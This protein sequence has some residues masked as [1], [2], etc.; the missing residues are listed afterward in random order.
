MT[1]EKGSAHSQLQKQ[2]GS[3]THFY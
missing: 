3:D 2:F 1:L